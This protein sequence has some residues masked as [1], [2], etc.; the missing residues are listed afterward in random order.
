M[1]TVF[2]CLFHAAQMASLIRSLSE[3][4]DEAVDLAIDAVLKGTQKG[5]FTEIL[6]KISGVLKPKGAIQKKR[7]VSAQ[8]E[9]RIP[10]DQEIFKSKILPLIRENILKYEKLQNNG[11]EPDWKINL[12]FIDSFNK[13]ELT[14]VLKIQEIHTEILTQEIVVGMIQVLV[15]FYRGLVY[16]HANKYVEGP[17]KEWYQRVLN[18]SYALMNKYRSFTIFV[19]CYPG[20]LMCGL[21]FTQL[22]K[23][24]ERILTHLES[25]YDMADQLRVHVTLTADGKEISIKAAE[26]KTIP[27]DSEKPSVDPDHMVFEQDDWF[28]AMSDPDEETVKEAVEYITKEAEEARAKNLQES[29]SK[30]TINKD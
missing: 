5:E 15:A 9:H 21:S 17:T 2:G 4:D 30:M 26:L 24:R 1:R 6:K 8:K 16:L 12:D 27:L 29:T 11:F 13:G 3:H 25:D 19:K 10:S 7:K 14:G 22:I 23:H 20:L 18:V 28:D